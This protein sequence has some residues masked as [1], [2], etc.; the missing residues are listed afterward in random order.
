MRL[1]CK[2]SI[3]LVAWIGNWRMVGL[4][5]V[6]PIP[7]IP[8]ANS[9]QYTT[10][11]KGPCVTCQVDSAG[12]DCSEGYTCF[13]GGWYTAVWQA[14]GWRKAYSCPCCQSN[15]Y[16]TSFLR[17]SV[18]IFKA[19][20]GIPSAE[21]YIQDPV[22]ISKPL[23]YRI[24]NLHWTSYIINILVQAYLLQYSSW[25]GCHGADGHPDWTCWRQLSSMNQYGICQCIQRNYKS[26]KYYIHKLYPQSTGKLC[27][28]RVLEAV[29]KIVCDSFWG[30]LCLFCSDLS[31]FILYD[32][33]F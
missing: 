3:W 4:H 24:P 15:I 14:A 11:P 8:A 21:K 18:L 9:L 20:H 28:Y 22:I 19:L 13:R 10:R 6:P 7:R 29:T 5:I 17:I 31:L 12:P 33:S 23:Q 2:R 27:M 26:A 32:Y 16:C 25:V 30:I 1:H